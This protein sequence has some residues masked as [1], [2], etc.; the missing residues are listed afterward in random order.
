MKLSQILSTSVALG[1]LTFAASSF[2]VPQFAISFDDTSTGAL[3]SQELVINDETAADGLNGTPGVVSG[4][5]STSDLEISSALSTIISDPFSLHLNGTL[6]TLTHEG[7]EVTIGASVTDM[8]QDNNW[9]FSIGGAA[10]D[11]VSAVAYIDYNNVLFGEGVL[12]GSIEL[13][14]VGGGAFSFN[15]SQL[16]L[17]PQLFTGEYS[18]SIFATLTHDGKSTSSFDAAINVPEPSII[19]LMGLGLIGMGVATRRKQKAA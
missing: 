15:S 3:G 1:A 19:A 5:Y 9:T 7:G 8:W 14:D 13:V 16:A 18:L 6:S 4:F 17:D 10:A 2:A 11:D 12:I